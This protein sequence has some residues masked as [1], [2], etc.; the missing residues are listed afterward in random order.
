ME[1][2]PLATAACLFIVLVLCTGCIMDKD[3]AAVIDE[4]DDG[5]I[6]SLRGNPTTGYG[7]T[8][9]APEGV[10][11]ES[12]YVPDIASGDICGSGGTFVFRIHSDTPGTYD[13][14]FS[15]GRSWEDAP[16]DVRTYSVTL[17]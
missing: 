10:D 3:G 7:W 2:W 15:Y 5:C 8:C 1:R 4:S 17:P 13:L 6:V 14:T 9:E 12:S 11:V 16:I